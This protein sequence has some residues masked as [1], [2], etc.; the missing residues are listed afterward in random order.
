MNIINSSQ[1]NTSSFTDCKRPNQ[2][3]LQYFETLPLI[4]RIE[5]I[6]CEIR[7]NLENPE[8]FSFSR[9]ISQNTQGLF[10]SLPKETQ[11]ELLFEYP[12]DVRVLLVRNFEQ[13]MHLHTEA[14]ANLIAETLSA[15]THAEHLFALLNQTTKEAVFE[16]LSFETQQILGL[17]PTETLQLLNTLPLEQKT[18]YIE[19][20]IENDL[21]N[22]SYLSYLNPFFSSSISETTQLLFASLPDEMQRHLFLECPIEAREQ[23]VPN[24]EVQVK[25]L[26]NAPNVEIAKTLQASSN[27]TQLF[28]LLNPESQIAIFPTLKRSLKQTF[29]MIYAQAL[30]KSN[31]TLEQIAELITISTHREVANIL[32]NLT[33]HQK[34]EL[35]KLLPQ[36]TLDFLNFFNRANFAHRIVTSEGFPLN[37]TTALYNWLAQV[38]TGANNKEF[39]YGAVFGP[40]SAAIQNYTCTDQQRAQDTCL[41]NKISQLIISCIETSNSA[42]NWVSNKAP[43]S[44]VSG[45]LPTNC[46]VMIFGDKTQQEQTFSSSDDFEK[47]GPFVSYIMPQLNPQKR[48]DETVLSFETLQKLAKGQDGVEFTSSFSSTSGMSADALNLFFPGGKTHPNQLNQ[49][50]RNPEFRIN[51]LFP[52]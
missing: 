5:L 7:N 2:Y 48:N 3:E 42:E 17:K 22:R 32:S 29:K 13:L 44:S 15:T 19:K 26:E 38:E 49:K 52:M 33:T 30:N 18:K 24:L 10:N 21:N 9:S 23:L 14:P 50:N 34:I 6:R 36:D 40:K 47:L 51:N 20:A 1:R 45:G 16:K 12:A 25:L 37:S 35:R 4:E 11:R 27:P 28:T 41:F 46:K 8:G 31:S 39:Q 43:L